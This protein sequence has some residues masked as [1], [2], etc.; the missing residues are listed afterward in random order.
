MNPVYSNLE[1]RCFPE[2]DDLG[3]DFLSR[4]D[5][6]LF[7]PARVDAAVADQFLQGESRDLAANR[8]EAR[9]DDRVRRVVDDD[10]GT[11]RQFEGADVP[12][13]SPDNS[14]LHLVVWERHG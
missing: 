4:F 13:L 12:A 7:D 14:A 6:D 3:V 9:D 2:L 10:I 1:T 11:G 5:D 8:I